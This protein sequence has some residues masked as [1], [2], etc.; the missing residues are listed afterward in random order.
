[1]PTLRRALKPCRVSGIF[2]CLWCA[3]LANEARVVRRAF[4]LLSEIFDIIKYGMD[5]PIPNVNWQKE[6]L[7][8]RAHAHQGN[9]NISGSTVGKILHEPFYRTNDAIYKQEGWRSITPT[10]SAII[11]FSNIDVDAT[12]STKVSLL[13]QLNWSSESSRHGQYQWNMERGLKYHSH[14]GSRDVFQRYVPI[15]WARK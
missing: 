6:I 9:I 15:L 2:K 12:P 13:P 5:R 11:L 7:R 3:T 10:Y 4:L 14:D 1:M 8:E